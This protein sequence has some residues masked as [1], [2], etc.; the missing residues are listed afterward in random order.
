MLL[1]ACNY[2]VPIVASRIGGIPDV[3]IDGKTGILLDDVG[4]KNV[5]IAINKLFDNPKLRQ[6]MSKNAKKHAKNFSQKIIG[7]LLKSEYESELAVK[8]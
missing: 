8:R 1:D 2:G 7:N 5:A 6:Q 3:V 4:G